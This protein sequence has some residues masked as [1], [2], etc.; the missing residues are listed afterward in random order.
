[1]DYPCTKFGDCT[2]SRFGFIV[3]T[4]RQIH[5]DRITVWTPTR[6]TATD[7]TTVRVSNNTV[8]TNS[9]YHIIILE[10]ELR[11]RQAEST[12]RIMGISVTFDPQL[13]LIHI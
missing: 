12:I 2:F 8:E 13:S 3:R 11:Y 1:M 5:T 4:D 6:M 10:M 9:R 7:A